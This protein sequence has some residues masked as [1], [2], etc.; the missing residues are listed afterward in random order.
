VPQLSLDWD[1][2][3]LRRHCP[4]LTEEAIE[5]ISN[6]NFID[7]SLDIKEYYDDESNTTFSIA[8]YDLSD[9]PEFEDEPFIGYDK[10]TIWGP[11]LQ[12]I[13]Y[14]DDYDNIINLFVYEGKD[15]IILDKFKELN[16]LMV[17]LYSHTNHDKQ[18]RIESFIKLCA[19][20]KITDH[21]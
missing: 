8:G 18:A 3:I 4:V 12:I 7:D 2:V 1:I 5:I 16:Q 21:T 14:V 20:C 19:N 11:L 13:K 17:F 9:H 10:P 15:A 6:T